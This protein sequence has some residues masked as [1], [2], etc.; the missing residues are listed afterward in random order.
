MSDGI[1][2]VFDAGDDD[3]PRSCRKPDIVM[4]ENNVF[5][6]GIKANWEFTEKRALLRS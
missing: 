6:L 4:D 2:L 1:L 5:E 3:L